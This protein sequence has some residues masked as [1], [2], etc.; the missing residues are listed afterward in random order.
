MSPNKKNDYTL[1]LEGAAE[2]IGKSV[3]TVQR[4]VK[5]RRLSQQYVAG[6]KGEEARLSKAEVL[7]LAKE[8]GSGIGATPNPEAKNGAASRGTKFG[9]EQVNLG[10]MELLKRHEQAMYRLG[11]LEEKAQQF[12]LIEERAKSLAARHDELSQ[13]DEEHRRTI[14]HLEHK[15][16][17]LE[18]EL[19][20]PLSAVERLTGK[21]QENH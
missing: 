13:K 7:G 19:E 15:V 12:V 17:R 18:R 2:L 8:I 3:R 1:S 6:P 21:R 16:S 11:Q 5:A 20:R 9:T 4:Y 14:A 10:I